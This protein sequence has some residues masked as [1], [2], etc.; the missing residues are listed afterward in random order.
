MYHAFVGNWWKTPILG[1]IAEMIPVDIFVQTTRNAMMTKKVNE[2][3]TE[4]LEKA[5]QEEINQQPQQITQEPTQQQSPKEEQQQPQTQPT[6][7]Q[8]QQTQDTQQ[9]Q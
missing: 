8:P 1:D 9:K 5:K 2:E 4:K 6:T 7:Q 3:E